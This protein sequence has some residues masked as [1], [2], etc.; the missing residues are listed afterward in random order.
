MIAVEGV[1]EVLGVRQVHQCM[2]ESRTEDVAFASPRGRWDWSEV[3]LRGCL[4]CGARQGVGC[5]DVPNTVVRATEGEGFD[6]SGNR[7]VRVESHGV[8]Q[9]DAQDAVEAII[10]IFAMLESRSEVFEVHVV[11]G[12]GRKGVAAV[13]P[14]EAPNR[15]LNCNGRGLR[16]RK[17]PDAKLL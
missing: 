14:E 11:I 6:D 2:Q 5:D 8:R 16:T 10:C 12:K 15:R 9:G 4:D 7:A 17:R 1:R 3:R 13:D